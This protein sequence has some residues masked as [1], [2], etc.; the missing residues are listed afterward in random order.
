VRLDVECLDG[1]RLPRLTDPKAEPVDGSGDVGGCLLSTRRL[2][3]LPHLGDA[4]ADGSLAVVEAERH[5]EVPNA[6]DRS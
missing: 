2:H 4:E 3:P 1:Q 5:A 6:A